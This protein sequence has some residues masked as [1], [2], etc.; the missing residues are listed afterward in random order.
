MAINLKK[1]EY[2]NL[3]RKMIIP[4]LI[5]EQMLLFLRKGKISKWFSGI[6]QEA[7]SVGLTSAVKFDDVILPMHRNLGVFTTRNVDYEKLFS[8]LMNR[9]GGFTK[10]RDRSFHFGTLEYNIVGIGRNASRSQWI[11]I[12]F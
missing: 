8:Q 3:Y 6:G 5:E 7:I 11:W 1:S 4:R 9:K 12:R 2:L 10:G